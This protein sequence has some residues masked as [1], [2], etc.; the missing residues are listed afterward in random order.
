MRLSLVV[1]GHLAICETF[2]LLRTLTVSVER[3][4]IG[5]STLLMAED[6]AIAKVSLRVKT[7]IKTYNRH[8]KGMLWQLKLMLQHERLGIR[9][10]PHRRACM[11][12]NMLET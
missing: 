7:G 10:S 3:A 9:R 2:V 6:E 11:P 12:A 5:P 4:L 8:G 1:F